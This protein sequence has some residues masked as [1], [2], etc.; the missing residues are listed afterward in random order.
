MNHAE[1][2]EPIDDE[3]IEVYADRLNMRNQLMGVLRLA[4]LSHVHLLET[5]PPQSTELRV[6]LMQLMSLSEHAAH[7]LITEYLDKHLIGQFDRVVSINRECPDLSE[8]FEMIRIDVNEPFSDTF[9]FAD[10]EKQH[11]STDK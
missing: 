7:Q 1:I 3:F 4:K 8:F 5:H 9:Y 2:D 11:V 6:A 10:G